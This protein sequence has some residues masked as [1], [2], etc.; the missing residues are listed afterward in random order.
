MAI[1]AREEID[2][3]IMECL[4]K[5]LSDADFRKKLIE[6]PVEAV[7][8]LTGKEIPPGIRIQILESDPSYDF[9][10]LL[11]ELSSEELD[12]ENL[13]DIVGGGNQNMYCND[14]SHQ[15]YC[16]VFCVCNKNSGK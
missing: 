5:A 15:G 16:Q 7:K 12:D 1:W 2:N 6:S 8:E 13:A 4:S 11:P 3:C 14:Y 10:F 9:T